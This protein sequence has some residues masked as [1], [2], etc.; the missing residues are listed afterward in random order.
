MNRATPMFS[1]ATLR[2]IFSAAFFIAA[3]SSADIGSMPCVK[4]LISGVLPSSETSDESIL[5][6][7]HAGLST[8]R[9]LEP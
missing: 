1:A 9:L 4:P 7:R 5:M 8:P 3:V 6:W 2:S